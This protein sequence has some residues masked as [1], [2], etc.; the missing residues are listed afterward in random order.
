[1]VKNCQYVLKKIFVS[2]LTE[3]QLY[4]NEAKQLRAL[5]HRNVI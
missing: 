2:D 3:A 1:M 4:A 5:H